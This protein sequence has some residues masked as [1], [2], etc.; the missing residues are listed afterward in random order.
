MKRPFK[1]RIVGIGEPS[2]IEVDMLEDE[3]TPAQCP[4]SQLLVDAN[5]TGGIV[6]RPGM[7]YLCAYEPIDGGRNVIGP[8]VRVFLSVAETVIYSV[9]ATAD[10]EKHW[11][12][13]LAAVEAFNSM[14]TDQ[15]AAFIKKA[16]EETNTA[17]NAEEEARLEM[18]DNYQ[19]LKEENAKLLKELEFI[20][21]GSYRGE[22]EPEKHWKVCVEHGKYPGLYCGAC[23]IIN[24]QAEKDLT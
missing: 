2:F 13:V 19:R 1:V 9:P 3:K 6:L 12:G 14:S 17:Q 10:H 23:E 20:K 11:E 4:A 16:V 15:Q 21:A 8:E 24:R 5:D 7:I 18:E 22:I